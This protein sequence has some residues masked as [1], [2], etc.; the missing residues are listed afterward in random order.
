M[1]RAARPAWIEPSDS[2]RW[3]AM[4]EP[5]A[6]PRPVPRWRLVVA[7]FTPAGRMRTLCVDTGREAA[8][9][10]AALRKAGLSVTAWWILSR[11]LPRRFL[12]LAVMA[13]PQTDAPGRPR[14]DDLDRPKGIVL[15]APDG[16]SR[17]SAIGADRA[18]GRR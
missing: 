3:E 16:E 8:A 14:S 6:R 9:I 11:R 13:T 7:W 2:W 4:L 17:T 1:T 5:E 10:E 15:P 18:R 12:R